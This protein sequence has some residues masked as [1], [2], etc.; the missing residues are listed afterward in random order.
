[1]KRP[2][3][4]FLAKFHVADLDFPK[5]TWYKDTSQGSRPYSRGKRQTNI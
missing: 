2:I 3:D 5:S 4:S 1:M